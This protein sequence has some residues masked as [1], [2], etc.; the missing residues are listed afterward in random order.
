MKYIRC[1]LCGKISIYN[2][3]E[4]MR[5]KCSSCNGELHLESDKQE[6]EKADEVKVETKTVKRRR[7]RVSKSSID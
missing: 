1:Y 4:P 6:A 2:D 7:K 5:K 3:G